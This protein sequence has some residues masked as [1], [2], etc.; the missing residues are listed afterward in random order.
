MVIDLPAFGLVLTYTG[1]RGLWAP[2]RSDGGSLVAIAGRA[3]FD[4]CEWNVAP[5]TGGQGGLAGRLI[6]DQYE[7]H[8]SDALGRL[9]GNCAVIL[10]DGARELLHLVT[11]CCGVLPAF[12]ADTA[13][14]L[15][16]GSHPDVVARTREKYL[17]AYRRLTGTDLVTAP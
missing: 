7:R 15:V 10:H 11:D 12:K 9:N 6:L 3:V 14:G 5:K 4:E 13:E 1:D 2:Y 8:G 16:Y 17:E